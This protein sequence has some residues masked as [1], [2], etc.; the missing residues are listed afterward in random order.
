MEPGYWIE[1][2]VHF[3]LCL[4]FVSLYCL[5]RKMRVD[6]HFDVALVPD[7]VIDLLILTQDLM[8]EGLLVGSSI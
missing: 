5:Q 7:Q 8:W 1:T 4:L 6:F 2:G 3:G